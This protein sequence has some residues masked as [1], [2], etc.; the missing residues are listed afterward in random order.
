MTLYAIDYELSRVTSSI[1]DLR[2]NGDR[3]IVRLAKPDRDVNASAQI[4]PIGNAPDRIMHKILAYISDTH[5]LHSTRPTA[6]LIDDIYIN[7]PDLLHINN[8]H[9]DYINLP[10]LA[11]AMIKMQIPTVITLP[12]NYP[13]TEDMASLFKRKK[14]NGRM[15]DLLFEMWDLL[16]V[17]APNKA[18]AEKAYTGSLQGH[19]IHIIEQNDAGLM[20]KEYHSL[21]HS[22]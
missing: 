4:R 22:L 12:E 14:F 6:N 2:K 16:F 18:V 7:R 10:F 15:W 8:A 1:M 17:V 21:F 13:A 3:C 11:Q 19:P 20:A 9:L 5:M